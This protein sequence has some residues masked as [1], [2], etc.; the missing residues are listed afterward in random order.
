MTTFNGVM[1]SV[2]AAAR[3][4]EREN[5]RRARE[6]DRM[7]KAQQ[8]QKVL[9]DASQDYQ[10]FTNYIDVIQSVHKGDIEPIEWE[11]ILE[12]PQPEKPILQH[13]HEE[14][15]KL[16]KSRYVPSFFDKLLGR[17]KKK[18]EHFEREMVI[19][20]SRDKSIHEA[21]LKKHTEALNDWNKLQLIAKGVLNREIEAYRDA[22]VYFNPFSEISALGSNLNLRIEPNHIEVDVYVNNTDI[23]PN[24]VL[25]LT[26]TG[27]LSRKNMPIARFNEL[28]QD[29]VCSCVLRIARE[30]LAHLPVK[31]VVVN[32]MGNLLN[33][34]TG[35]VEEQ[36][37]VSVAVYP[38]TFQY[39]NF[40]SVDPSDCMSNFI[41]NMR[42]SKN[43]GLAPV[44]KIESH[45]LSR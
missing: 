42:F 21:E 8:K 6:A 39:I 29:H 1:R 26:S 41:H 3:R 2:S 12:E 28:Y 27:K 40:E 22:L 7:Y 25:T 9:A 44:Q 37:V 13:T 10:S 43:A 5:H 32:A 15:A 18:V 20:A 30:A 45:T 24:Y 11:L 23:I 34:K 4:A 35:R 19:G 14:R 16:V 38:E 36:A 33:S 17:T 31:F